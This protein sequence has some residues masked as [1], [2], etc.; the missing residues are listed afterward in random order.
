M[1]LLEW[2]STI[3]HRRIGKRAIGKCSLPRTPPLSQSKDGSRACMGQRTTGERESVACGPSLGATTPKIPGAC[4]R[5]DHGKRRRRERHAWTDGS[6]GST[7][8]RRGTVNL[9]RSFPF[10]P[11]LAVTA[12]LHSKV[13]VHIGLLDGTTKGV[14]VAF[15]ASGVVVCQQYC[16]LH[17]PRHFKSLANFPPESC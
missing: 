11:S 3:I 7:V 5:Q 12:A 17:S 4:S 10:P 14:T 16:S 9:T 1:Q 15:C 2:Q 6:S 13:L 8:R